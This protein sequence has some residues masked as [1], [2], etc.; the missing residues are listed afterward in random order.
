MLIK[1]QPLQGDPLVASVTAQ[2]ARFA[3][4]SELMG[5]CASCLRLMLDAESDVKI[6]VIEPTS[7]GVEHST[8]GPPQRS[9]NTPSG[10]TLQ[11]PDAHKGHRDMPNWSSAKQ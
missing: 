4:N 8:A 2:Q 5:M 11:V 3:P 6:H 7:V 9:E 10:P 1:Q